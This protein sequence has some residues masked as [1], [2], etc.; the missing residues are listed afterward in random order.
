MKHYVKKHLTP[1]VIDSMRIS[2]SAYEKKMSPEPVC[3]FCGD[4]TPVT[5]YAAMRMSTGEYRH[6]WRW[7]ACSTCEMLLDSDDTTGVINRII[8]RM[9]FLT[10]GKF[11]RPLITQAASAAFETFT[12][13]A[14]S[15]DE[16]GDGD[17]GKTSGV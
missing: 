14:V 10:G 4:D 8:N 2:L 3:D 13:Y 5:V 15:I 9:E 17:D 7:C 16:R 1:E 11:S 6:A 12:R